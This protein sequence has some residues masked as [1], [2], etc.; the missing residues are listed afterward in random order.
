MPKITKK[1]FEALTV[2]KSGLHAQISELD[3]ALRREP[4]HL[5]ADSPEDL[6]RIQTKLED[7]SA[8]IPTLQIEENNL[9]NE[10][11]STLSD[12]RDT[13][14][15]SWMLDQN[16]LKTHRCML[17]FPLEN[18]ARLELNP[19]NAEFLKLFYAINK[20]SFH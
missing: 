20:L 6:G 16:R 17:R 5:R 3:F 18:E 4:Y 8:L 15:L 12:F 7:T 1:T 10:I 13:E 9:T 19:K 11:E 14:E 2:E